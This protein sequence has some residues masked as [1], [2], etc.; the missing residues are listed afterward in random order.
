MLALFSLLAG[1]FALAVVDPIGYPRN[2]ALYLAR[3]ADV[4]AQRRVLDESIAAA[5]GAVL[6][7]AHVESARVRT[8][9]TTVLRRIGML[10]GGTRTQEFLG[11]AT[12]SVGAAV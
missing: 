8:L 7:C 9:L 1:F 3:L 12:A 4:L 2:Y 5:T 6:A 10:D 11:W